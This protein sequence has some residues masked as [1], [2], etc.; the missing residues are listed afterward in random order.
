MCRSNRM[1]WVKDVPTKEYTV[2]MDMPNLKD[3]HD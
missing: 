2:Q 3:I 1:C